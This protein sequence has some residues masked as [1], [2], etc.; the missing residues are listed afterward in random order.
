MTVYDLIRKMSW[1]PAHSYLQVIVTISP[2]HLEH[3]LEEAKRTG[4]PI[5]LY[6]DPTGVEQHWNDTIVN[7][8]CESLDL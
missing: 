6:A 7:I 5:E 1:Y 3:Y 4:E 2:E 8:N